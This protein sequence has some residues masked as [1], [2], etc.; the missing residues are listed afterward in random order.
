MEKVLFLMIP[1]IWGALV[2]GLGAMAWATREW[3]LEREGKNT[4]RVVLK[5]EGTEKT[6]EAFY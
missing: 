1:V 3:F 5:G 4:C 2:L 6:E